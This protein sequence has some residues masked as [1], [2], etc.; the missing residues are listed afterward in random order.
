M[1]GTLP[2]QSQKNLFFPAR[3]KFNWTKVPH[4]RGRSRQEETE[5]KVKQAKEIGLPYVRD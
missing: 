5:R 2:G 3:I 1:Q 4:K